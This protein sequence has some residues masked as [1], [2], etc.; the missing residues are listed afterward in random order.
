MRVLIATDAWHPQVNGVVRTY[1]RIAVELAALGVE[2]QVVSPDLFPT[3]PCPTYPE[4]RLALPHPGRIAELVT[5]GGAEA[6]HIATE[7]PVGWMTRRLCLAR[8]IPFTTSFHTRFPDYVEQRT[9]MPASWTWAIE[10]RFHNAGAGTMVAAPSLAAEL[11][12]RGFERILPWTRGVDIVRFRPRPVRLFGPGPVFLYVGRVAIEKNL[13]AFL[14]LDLPGQKVVVGDGPALAE[15]AA[16]HSETHFAGR[17]SGEA[18]AECYA[19]ADVFV[20]PSRTDTFGIV[21][22]EAMASGLPVA[23]FPVTGPIDLVRSGVGG[24]LSENLLDAA[25]AALRVNRQTVR[26]EA[27]RYSWS[28]SA[29]IFLSNLETAHAC[30]VGRRATRPRVAAGRSARSA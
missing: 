21:L 26:R 14:A 7:G 24:V 23:A 3:V 11:V 20:F 28:A 2:V 25:L 9:G 15:L 4:I 5:G 29:R 27:E 16:R 22:L 30:P 8:G 19:S 1:E 12:R 13:D 17:R 18:L 10:R 6:V